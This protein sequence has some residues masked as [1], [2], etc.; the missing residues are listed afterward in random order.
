MSCD[1]I[2][3]LLDPYRDGELAAGER[4]LVA[5][6]AATCRACAAILDASENVA[7]HLKEAGPMAA[8]ADLQARV[9]AALDQE[10]LRHMPAARRYFPVAA[11]GWRQAAAIAF[12]SAASA[13]GGWQA[14]RLGP[15]PDLVSEAA[16]IGATQVV[17]AHIRALLQD[18]PLQVASSDSHTVRPWFAGRIEIAPAVQDFA[19][20]GFPLIGGRLDLIGGQRVGVVVYKRNA[21][22]INVYMSPAPGTADSPPAATTR[23]GYNLLT[24]TRGGITC[25]A[26]S[27]LN[28]AGLRQLQALL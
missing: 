27:D 24:W 11:G 7:R 25:W 13:F 6:H 8:P 4:A 21:H 20:D 2:R 10:D 19:K 26:V 5:G 1:K 23:N 3:P 28:A 22:W 17:Q 18:N 15:A 14:A 9:L 12:V 16:G